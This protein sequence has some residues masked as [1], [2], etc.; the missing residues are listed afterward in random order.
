[1]SNFVLIIVQEAFQIYLLLYL[2]LV[3]GKSASNTCVH[4]RLGSEFARFRAYM[5]LHE[6]RNMQCNVN[7]TAIIW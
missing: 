4:G 1:M 3:K 2:R 7:I 5:H 6:K